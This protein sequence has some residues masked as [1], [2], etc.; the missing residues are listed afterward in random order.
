MLTLC[1]LIPSCPFS[2][3]ACVSFFQAWVPKKSLGVEKGLTKHSLFHRLS[4]GDTLPHISAM[5]GDAAAE[6]S[7]EKTEKAVGDKTTK[8]KVAVQVRH[9]YGHSAQLPS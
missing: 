7:K 6:Q 3:T 1:M 8:Q 4:E 2:D 9:G 5:L